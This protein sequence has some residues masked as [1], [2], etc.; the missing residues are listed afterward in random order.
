MV[1][2]CF[3]IQFQNYY[4]VFQTE[5]KLYTFMPIYFADTDCQICCFIDGNMM[6]YTNETKILFIW[7]S[8]SYLIA[9]IVVGLLV[10]AAVVAAVVG[11][12]LYKKKNKV[13]IQSNENGSEH[14]G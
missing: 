13:R 12:V 1:Y 2:T 14:L 8:V 5:Y 6:K 7:Y 9:G 4:E 10:L 3:P 11:V